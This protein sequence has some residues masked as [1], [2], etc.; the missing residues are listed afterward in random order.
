MQVH[1]ALA[2][3]W[4]PDVDVRYRRPAAWAPDLPIRFGALVDHLS[5]VILHRG[6]RRVL[7]RACCQALGVTRGREDH[8]RPRRHQVGDGP[9]ADHVPRLPRPLHPV[10]AMTTFHDALLLRVRRA[11]AP[12]TS[13]PGAAALAG[14]STLFGSTLLTV[15]AG[16]A[17][18]AARSTMVVLSLRGAADGLS[19]VVPHA[20][21]QYYAARPRIAIPRSHPARQGRPVRPPPQP[22]APAA[23]VEQREASRPCTRP[24]CRHRTAPTSPRWRR[25]RTP[26]RAPRPASGGSTG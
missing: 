26:T 20:D 10:T 17:A 15:S 25:S 18:A 13:S 1:F 14:T 7:L 12:R 23:A 8:P 21:P 16:A 5:Q 19:L 3:G 4:W 11:V 6:P 2:G 22:R 9:A 24:G